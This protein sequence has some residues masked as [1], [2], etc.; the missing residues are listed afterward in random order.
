MSGNRRGARL[1]CNRCRCHA[2]EFALGGQTRELNY[3]RQR[4]RWRRCKQRRIGH[5]HDGADGANIARMITRVV[6]GCGLPCRLAAGNLSGDTCGDGK[7]GRDRAKFKNGRRS[8]GNA[9]EMAE[10]QRKLDA[11]R[12]QRYPGP[13]LD[14][15]PEPLHAETHLSPKGPRLRPNRRYLSNANLAERCQRRALGASSEFGHSV[16][17]LQRLALLA[18]NHLPQDN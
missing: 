11:Q 1:K 3:L 14:V 16:G 6:V 2:S 7:L 8:G 9:V 4:Q 17:F 13:A 18:M 15:R 10:R 12:K 5:R